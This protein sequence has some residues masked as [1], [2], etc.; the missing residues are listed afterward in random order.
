MMPVS[1]FVYGIPKRMLRPHK[2][3]YFLGRMGFK[4]SA[5]LD[6]AYYRSENDI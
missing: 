6:F 2:S 4:K 3:S 5:L 1:N